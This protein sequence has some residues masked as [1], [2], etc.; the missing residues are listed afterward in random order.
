MAQAQRRL[1]QL[2]IPILILYFVLFSVV[3]WLFARHLIHGPV[4][5]ALAAFPALP[6]IAVIVLLVRYLR[7][8]TDEFKRA[9]ITEAMLWSIGLTM[10]L[11]TA[12]GF[13]EMFIPNMHISVLW[14]FPVFCVTAAVSK[15]LV[16]RR[17][18]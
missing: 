10:T 13:I 18:Q 15:F 5:Y 1:R 2:A 8:E 11:T 12:W 6:L 17:F 9:V 14:V 4:S 16:R 3:D 7:E